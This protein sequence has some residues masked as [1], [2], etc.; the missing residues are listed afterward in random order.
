MRHSEVDVVSSFVDI[1]AVVVLPDEAVEV[2]F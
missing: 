1:E 2:V